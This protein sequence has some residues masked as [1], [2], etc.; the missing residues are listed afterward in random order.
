M[1]IPKTPDG[2]GFCIA[3]GKKHGD[4]VQISRVIKGSLAGKLVVGDT[5]VGINGVS[6]LNH[7]HDQMVGL[8]RSIELY[9]YVS[10]E[11]RRG[12]LLLEELSSRDP[13]KESDTSVSFWQV[14]EATNTVIIF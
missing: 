5:L 10:I 13:A 3:G 11:V 6:V 9:S 8:F 1:R 12:T 7:T 2:M 14:F 4:C